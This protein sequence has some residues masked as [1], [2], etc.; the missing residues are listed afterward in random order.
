MRFNDKQT[1]SERIPEDSVNLQRRIIP[2][3]ERGYK[4]EPP[5]PLLLLSQEPDND[6]CPKAEAT[7][8][9]GGARVA[10]ADILKHQ[11]HVF[12]TT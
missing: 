6:A 12:C 4:Q 8:H 11:R 9:E 7:P 3:A 10:A 2:L 1:D 5:P